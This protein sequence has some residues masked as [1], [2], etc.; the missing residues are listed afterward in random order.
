MWIRR[1]GK[2][3]EQNSEHEEDGDL[4]ENGSG[5][6]EFVDTDNVNHNALQIYAFPAVGEDGDSSHNDEDNKNCEIGRII[7]VI[8]WKTNCIFRISIV[9]QIDKLLKKKLL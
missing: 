6:D 4:A 2:A 5:N 1:E 9:I 8:L 7:M 3:G